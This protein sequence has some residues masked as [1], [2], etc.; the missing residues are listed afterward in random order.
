[1]HRLE[2]VSADN[3]D[4][5]IVIAQMIRL[6]HS[7]SRKFGNEMTKIMKGRVSASQFIM[8]RF[9][10]QC[11]PAKV[12]QISRKMQL[13]PSAI[14]FMTKDLLERDLIERQRDTKD[15]RVVYISI[16]QEGLEVVEEIEASIRQSTEILLSNLTNLDLSNI[17]YILEKLDTS[18]AMA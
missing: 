2:S 16:T 10:K 11:G 13:T 3:T 1:M 15:R 7:I 6:I 17:V 8:L 5:K 9:L 4:R 14:T 12:S 18:L